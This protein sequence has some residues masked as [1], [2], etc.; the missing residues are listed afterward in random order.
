LV[1]VSLT[2]LTLDFRDTGPV[3]A[4]G[5]VVASVF[6]PVRKAGAWVGHPFGN[7]WSS[8]FRYSKVKQQNRTLQRKV[9]KLEAVKKHDDIDQ[10]LYR[11]LLAQAHITYL[12]DLPTVAAQVTSG[13]VSNFQ[14]TI[15]ID[16]GSGDGVKVGM[17]VVTDL[18]LVGRVAEVHGGRST[19]QP[20]TD[21]NLAFFV[22]VYAKDDKTDPGTLGEAHGT[23]PGKDVLVDNDIPV[24]ARVSKGDPVYTSGR[25]TSTYPPGIPIGVVRSASPTADRT[26]LA[27]RVDPY[28]DFDRLSIVRVV[29]WEPTP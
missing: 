4:A 29:L 12:K 8:A 25:K 5:D 16:R 24:T 1:L 28:V 9:D 20:I 6:N 21:P 13:P 19:V 10:R 18:G 27:V 23:G 26:Q 11:Q 2:I 17:A 22:K 14:D 3:N 15:E 7:L